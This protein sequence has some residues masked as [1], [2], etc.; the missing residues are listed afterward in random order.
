MRAVIASVAVLF[1]IGCGGGSQ[2]PVSASLPLPKP[3]GSAPEAGE[4]FRK[5]KP[6]AGK[7]RDFKLPALQSFELGNW[8]VY[9]MEDHTLPVV[10]VDLNFDGGFATDPKGRE[11][12]AALCL[13]LVTYGTEKLDQ[14]QFRAAMADLGSSVSAYT[15]DDTHGIGFGSLTKTFD[16]TLDLYG[17]M[18]RTPGM[19]DKD[20]KRLVAR[21]TDTV[22]Q[23]KASPPML[24]AR[25]ASSLVW[26]P[27][28][29]G[30]R[31][32]T[33]DSLG[34]LS[35][36]ACKTFHKNHLKGKP[37]RLFVF[38]DITP[39]QIKEKFAPLATAGKAR[40]QKLRIA[41]PKSRSGKVFFTNIPGA[42]QSTVYILHLGPRRND[43]AFF[44]NTLMSRILSSGFASRINMNVREDKGYSYGAR[45][46]LRYTRDAGAYVASSDIR[47]DAT[48]QAILEMLGEMEDLKTGKK[49]PLAEELAREQ[50]GE[51]LALPAQFAT[52]RSALGQYRSLLYYDLPLDTFNHYIDNV[53]KVTLEDVQAAANDVLRPDQA[54]IYV[55][56]DGEAAQLQRKDG[57]DVPWQNDKGE[58]VKLK[59]ALQQLRADEKV[60]SVDGDGRTK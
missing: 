18:L 17:D 13:D 46:E 2:K 57:K 45:G 20:L 54:L 1:A 19:R 5:S 39:D 24:A 52:A 58:P 47:S 12:Q 59:D 22:R 37:A 50:S 42:S 7:E 4:D 28:Y 14:A 43:P 41:P 8:R 11:G 23:Q 48:Y 33:E 15:Q 49:P 10:A 25:V 3:V 44:A 29:P 38:G 60:I 6:E 51:I 16:Q 21:S 32:V 36:S 53:R 55:V 31:I 56:G 40:A 30:G 27:N 26:G 9:L 34:K 35:T